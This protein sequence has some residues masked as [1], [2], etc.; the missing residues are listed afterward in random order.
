MPFAWFT[1]HIGYPN[2]FNDAGNSHE[3]ASA[4]LTLADAASAGTSYNEAKTLFELDPAQVETKKAAFQEFG[5]LYVL[6]RSNELT[7]TPLGRQIQTFCPTPPEA[8]Q[9]RRQVLLVLG[10]ALAR[11]QFNN[12]LPVGGNKYR[13]RAESTEHPALSSRLLPDDEAGWFPDG[14][15]VARCRVRHVADV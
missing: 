13:Q 1:S 2:F 4:F 15:R 8:S 5:L 9:N 14:Q 6:P 10:R 11:Y 3:L 7:L 12:P